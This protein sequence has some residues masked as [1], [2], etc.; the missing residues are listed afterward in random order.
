MAKHGKRVKRHLTRPRPV[1]AS[2]SANEDSDLV[3]C[4]GVVCLVDALGMRQR[5]V[6]EVR[7]FFKTLT[8][9]ENKLEL[10]FNNTAFQIR[11]KDGLWKELPPPLLTSFGDSVLIAMDFTPVKSREMRVFLT[12]LLIS[13]VL[14]Q[15]PMI[16]LSNGLTDRS[17]V[18][19]RG[20][21]GIGEYCFRTGSSG[22]ACL[23]PAIAAVAANYER[24]QAGA[25]IIDPGLRA[26]LE[27]YFDLYLGRSVAA[28]GHILMWSDLPMKA[29]DP[30]QGEVIERHLCINPVESPIAAASRAIAGTSIIRPEEFGVGY[31]PGEAPYELSQRWMKSMVAELRARAGEGNTSAHAKIDRTLALFDEGLEA[32][33]A[34]SS[35]L[36]LNELIE[37]VGIPAMQR[38]M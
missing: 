35:E 2:T 17:G 33:H 24:P 20:S 14:S 9:I 4:N 34:A 25:I 28:I 6:D 5:G 10:M 27:W 31:S 8:F 26:E 32:T 7:G 36:S 37:K 29:K 38:V 30:I 22:K 1:S 11:E 3:V 13:D 16:G 15:I 19:F 18:L 23:G 12:L 21:V